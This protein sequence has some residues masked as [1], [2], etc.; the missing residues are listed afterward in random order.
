MTRVTRRHFGKTA[1]AAWLATAAGNRRVF[2]ANNRVRL[3]FIGVGNRGDQ[4]LDAFVA[5]KDAEIVAVCDIH[6]PYV[7]LAARKAGGTPAQLSDYRKLLEMKDV[8]AVV[9]ATPDHWHALQMIQA[10]EAGKDVY[11]EKPLSLVVSEGRAMVDAAR[12]H[13]RVV[14]VGIH[15]RSAAMWLALTCRMKS[16]IGGPPSITATRKTTPSLSVPHASGS[17]AMS[18]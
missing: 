11:V 15:R 18:V 8:D 7:A 14:Q 6:E 4:V 10:C 9:I 17:S 1:A 16:V 5:H 3:G 13:N 12:Q 2:G